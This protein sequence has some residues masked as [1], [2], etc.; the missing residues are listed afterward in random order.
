M[1]DEISLES[2][3]LKYKIMMT[4][5]EWL[6]IETVKRGKSI[7]EA[8]K[9]LLQDL[10]KDKYYKDFE[11][12]LNGEEKWNKMKIKINNDNVDILNNFQIENVNFILQERRII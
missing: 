3:C 4:T 6:T 9:K 5:E 11:I 8:I 7:N 10:E 12:Y 1:K 2:Y